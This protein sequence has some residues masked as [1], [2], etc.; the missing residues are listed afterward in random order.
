MTLQLKPGYPEVL[1]SV[2]GGKEIRRSNCLVGEGVRDTGCC[3]KY[4]EL[5]T[6]AGYSGGQVQL[7]P[8]NTTCKFRGD[9]AGPE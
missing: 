5:G 7:G 3:N 1:Q 8:G 2:S 9:Q 4:A 6:K